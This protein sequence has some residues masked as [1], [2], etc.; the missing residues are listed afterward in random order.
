[1]RISYKYTK[2]LRDV[3]VPQAE[4]NLIGHPVRHC[5]HSDWIVKMASHTEDLSICFS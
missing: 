3:E 1:M 2:H 5:Y 4:M